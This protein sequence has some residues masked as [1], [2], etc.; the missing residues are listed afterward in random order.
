MLAKA[1]SIEPSASGSSERSPSTRSTFS[2]PRASRFSRAISS[3]PGELSTP[4]T[5]PTLGA[6]PAATKPVPVPTSTTCVGPP[7]CEETPERSDIR[8]ITLSS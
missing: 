1:A 6:R 5:R 8:F 7:L 4:I 3:I 2:A